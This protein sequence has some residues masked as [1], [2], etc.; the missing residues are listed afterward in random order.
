MFDNKMFTPINILV[1]CRNFAI[2]LIHAQNLIVA[3]AVG[4]FLA[5]P[6]ENEETK[7]SP[8]G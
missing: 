5:R 4:S 8:Y 1:N 7:K 3:M 6:K 2:E